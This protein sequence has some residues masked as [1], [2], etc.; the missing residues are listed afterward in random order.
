MAFHGTKLA[1][2]AVAGG[3]LMLAAPA[4]AGF[5][6]YEIRNTPTIIDGG[7]QIEFIIDGGTVR[8]P[9]LVG[10]SRAMDMILSGRPVDAVAATRSG[11]AIAIPPIQA[12]RRRTARMANG[13]YTGFSERRAAGHPQRS[14]AAIRSMAELGGCQPFTWQART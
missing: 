2:L 6:A 14:M 5:T 12:S 9:R 4:Q 10:Q 7:G 8:L 13:T 3:L 11:R 1:A